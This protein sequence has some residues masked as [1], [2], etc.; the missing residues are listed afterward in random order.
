MRLSKLW[1]CLLA[2]AA[3]M[4]TFSCREDEVPPVPSADL[5]PVGCPGLREDLHVLRILQAE[6]DSD[7]GSTFY[8]P[9][10]RSSSL[11][12]FGRSK[13][14]EH[15]ILFWD[16]DYKTATP[17]DAA[18]P[19]H[20]DTDTFLAWCEEIYAYYVNTLKFAHYTDAGQVLPGPVQVPDLP[21]APDGV[22]GLWLRSGRQHHRVP[23]GESGGG[24]QPCHRG[25]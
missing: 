24:E 6:P 16:K 10:K 14:S 11:Y 17:D 3:V 8:D 18:A 5:T 13:Q 19:Y 1:A 20:L 4:L 12:Y 21:V 25:P 2:A 15:F 7:P 22:G 23:V 9:L